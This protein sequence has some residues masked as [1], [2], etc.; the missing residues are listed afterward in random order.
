M[1]NPPFARSLGACVVALALAAHIWMF[2]APGA[3]RASTAHDAASVSAAQ[4]PL[5]LAGCPT[6][7]SACEVPMPTGPVVLLA[8]VLVMAAPFVRRGHPD[9]RAATTRAR[10]STER[11]PPLPAAVAASVVLLV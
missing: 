9:H 6:G 1:P 4:T 2:E 3:H 8:L 11:S 5:S 7:M 10:P